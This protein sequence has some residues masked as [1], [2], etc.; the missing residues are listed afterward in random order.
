LTRWATL[1]A[2][3]NRYGSSPPEPVPAD[4]LSA[5]RLGGLPP[6][7]YVWIARYKGEIAVRAYSRPMDLQRPSAPADIEH[8]ELF[9]IA[10]GEL[11]LQVGIFG[12][13]GRGRKI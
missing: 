4:W 10:V 3:I 5:P 11:A 1:T 12:D 2:V 8:G 13:P 6:N 9:T 7:T